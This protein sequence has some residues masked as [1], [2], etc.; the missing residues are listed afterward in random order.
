MCGIVIV[1]G[2][3]CTTLTEHYSLGLFDRLA[4][5][6]HRVMHQAPVEFF[7]RV[8]VIHQEGSPDGSPDDVS[9]LY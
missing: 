3:A 1:I 7:R 6:A 9:F 5:P 4:E 2:Q 8:E